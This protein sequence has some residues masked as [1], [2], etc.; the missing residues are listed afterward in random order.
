MSDG[1]PVI[2]YTGT[3][4]QPRF[5]LETEKGD[6]DLG[7]R[8]HRYSSPW[9]VAA[10]G[11]KWPYAGVRRLALVTATAV[12]LAGKGETTGSVVMSVGGKL[13]ILSS[14]INLDVFLD[15][16]TKVIRTTKKISKNR[17]KIMRE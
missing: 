8:N 16:V 17:S 12:L 15:K 1:T 11:V 3:N 10:R 13:W 14:K 9:T 4:S 6:S 5:S 2:M 7:R